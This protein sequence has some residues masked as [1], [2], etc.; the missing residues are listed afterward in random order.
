MHGRLGFTNGADDN[1]MDAQG[2]DSVQEL[3]SLNDDDAS[4][5]CRTIRRPGGHI[6]NPAFVAG[7]PAVV[8]PA[9]AV[10]TRIPCVG[11]MVLQ[12][13]ETNMKLASFTV[14]HCHRISRRLSAPATNPASIR[15]L[16]D[17]KI[18]ED[19]KDKD[20]PSVPTIDPPK[21]WP[22]TID[23]FQDHF[24]SVLGETKAPLACMICDNA[25]VPPEADDPATNCSA[26]EIE[27]TSR[28]PHQD[29]Q[30]ADLPAFIHDRSKVWQTLAE[31]RREDKCWTHLKPLQ[32]TRDGRGAFLAIHAR[33]LGANHVN[34]MANAA[35][36]K[37]NQAK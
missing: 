31:A 16:C 23:S 10:P 4:D 18:K 25:T 2:V 26:P 9:V 19:S 22:K 8:P 7:A 17:L 36:A 21:S 5:L 1:I 24:S 15:H 3:G 37:L 6:A 30:G 33:Y 29:P 14:R 28:M 20:Q 34:N 27:M 32:R 11:I 12:R 35:E 13:A